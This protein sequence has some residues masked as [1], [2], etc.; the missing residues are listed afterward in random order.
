MD[1]FA[2]MSIAQLSALLQMRKADPVD[3]GE[4]VFEAIEAYSDKSVFVTLLKDRA[5]AEAEAS[6]RRLRDNRSLGLLD[7]IPIAWKDLF[8]MEGMATTAGS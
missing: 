3:V 8:D 7:G 5:R 1:N 4:A 6:S 2:A